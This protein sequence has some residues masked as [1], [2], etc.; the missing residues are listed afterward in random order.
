M[1]VLVTGAT[2]SVGRLVTDHLLAA[3]VAVRALT[4]DP[5]AAA[6]PDGAE[7]WAG[8]LL[9]PH[10]LTAALHGVER[11][12]LFPVPE[13]ARAV[14]AAA[15]EAGV[16]R[17][18]V[19]SSS[20]VLDTSGDNHS[21]EHHRAVERA[22]AESGVEWTFV[23][24]DEF[25]S[26]VLWKWAESIRTE[27]VVRAPYGAAPRVPVHEADVAAVAAAALLEDGHAGQAYLL[28]GP[29]AITQSGQVRAIARAVGRPIAFEEITPDQAR[30]DMAAAMPAPV[31][32]MV[33]RY[34]ADAVVHPPVPVDTVE[35]VTG[36]PARTFA[37]WVADHAADF[38]PRPA[39]E[40]LARRAARDEEPAA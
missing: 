40:P 30:K 39:A 5:A 2:G 7:V 22:V 20:S 29:E 23:R 28:T 14:V 38:A 34:L 9:R 16:R 13:T 32:E 26:N 18:V 21:G 27:G 1:T 12:Y 11:L 25:A 35:R 31:V 8:D 6:L 19:L 15:E 33:L 37:R 36:R 24:P 3:G 17:I 10:T 4:R